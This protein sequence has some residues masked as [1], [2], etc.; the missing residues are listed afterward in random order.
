MLTLHSLELDLP[1]FGTKLA[2]MQSLLETQQLI[3]AIISL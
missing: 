3:S 1:A 2:M